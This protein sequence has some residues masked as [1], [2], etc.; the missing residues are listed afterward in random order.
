MTRFSDTDRERIR[1]RLIEE[2]RTLF[3]QFGFERTRI[4]DVTEAVGI[5]T[6]TFYQF[7]DSKA[8]L[9]VCVLA[10][11]REKL[12]EEIDAA[13]AAAGS[14]REEVR[15]LLETL[16]S[17]VRSNPLI[18]RVII[19]NELSAIEE[20]LSASEREALRET[21]Y[22]T[23]LSYADEWVTHESFR[24]DDPDVVSGMIRSLVF[25]TRARER[26]VAEVEEFA[27]YEVIEA[28]L[29]ETVV[30]GLFTDDADA[31]AA[32]GD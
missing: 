10:L 16:L 28:A 14:P 26:S 3:T 7:F 23:D 21:N 18:S 15:T 12:I 20:R 4:S 17:T 19:E 25:V 32:A 8:A 6:S 30:E 13:T 1:S 29:I 5:G 31:S 22:D 24:Y 9:Y 2:G 27:P 11:E